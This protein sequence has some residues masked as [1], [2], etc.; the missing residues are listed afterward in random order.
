MEVQKYPVHPYHLSLLEVQV[1][2]LIQ[3][4]LGVPYHQGI[5][6]GL[7]IQVDHVDPRIKFDEIS[8]KRFK[9]HNSNLVSFHSRNSIQ[10]T[11]SRET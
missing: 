5:Q 3:V 8:F 4:Y 1:I 7:Q 10:S 9:A 2:H 6:L 11:W